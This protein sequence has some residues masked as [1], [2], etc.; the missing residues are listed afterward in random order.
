MLVLNVSADFAKT[1]L[2][3]FGVSRA[4][5]GR[6]AARSVKLLVASSR[7]LCWTLDDS[8]PFLFPIFIIFTVAGILG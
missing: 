3:R 1:A 6:W 7:F 8:L 5:D 2:M 4:E